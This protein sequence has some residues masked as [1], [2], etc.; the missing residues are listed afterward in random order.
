MLKSMWESIRTLVK[1]KTLNIQRRRC[2]PGKL[3]C[4]QRQISR[5]TSG[6][7]LRISSC[8]WSLLHCLLMF[9]SAVQF[10]I[11][12]IFNAND[13]ILTVAFIPV[14][15]PLDSSVWRHRT[16]CQCWRP[17]MELTEHG[18]ADYCLMLID[19]D[20]NLTLAC[21]CRLISCNLSELRRFLTSEGNH[22]CVANCLSTSLI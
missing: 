5:S 9:L 10:V 16:S 21:D 7:L 11:N 15:L 20:G 22:G 13:E 19:T 14:G 12:D 1:G 8:Q 6:L 18:T 3:L 4:N 17:A 2:W